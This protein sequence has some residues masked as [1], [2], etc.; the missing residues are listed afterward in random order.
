MN[1][2]KSKK[3]NLKSKKNKKR[4]NSFKKKTKKYNLRGGEYNKGIVGML[5]NHN[6]DNNS[7]NINNST[8]D[9][10]TNPIKKLIKDSNF[11]LEEWVKNTNREK[12]LTIYYA[13][14][15]PLVEDGENTTINWKNGY[16][17]SGLK[18]KSKLEF[19][20]Y[21]MKKLENVGGNNSDKNS[22][23]KAIET[24]SIEDQN[25]CGDLLSKIQND[26]MNVINNR[27]KLNNNVNKY[28]NEMVNSNNH[29]LDVQK[30]IMNK[31][32]EE[33][34]NNF[35]KLCGD[36]SKLNQNVQDIII[37]NQNYNNLIQDYFSESPNF[38][39]IINVN[40]DTFIFN[41]LSDNYLDFVI[42]QGIDVN[43]DK[44]YNFESPPLNI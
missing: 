39:N 7:D 25:K 3:K 33:L 12:G 29:Y 18:N 32:I 9:N 38:G 11:I 40:K 20:D 30:D 1:I 34:K 15:I 13:N 43:N 21:I 19:S 16:H 44:E 22:C 10:N 17:G 42:K 8:I 31:K 37:K 5:F 4:K 2:L 6:D 24:R 27:I 36:T 35:D 28:L 26:D 41:E 23:L 14:E